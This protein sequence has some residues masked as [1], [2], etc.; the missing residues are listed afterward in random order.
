MPT[1]DDIA[2]LIHRAIEDYIA[3]V[4]GDITDVDTLDLADNIAITLDVQKLLNG[5]S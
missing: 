1:R 5:V 4:G 3:D 2:D